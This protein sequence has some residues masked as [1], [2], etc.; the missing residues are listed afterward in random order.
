MTAVK[1]MVIITCA[2]TG[3]GIKGIAEPRFAG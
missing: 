3:L 1:G 2:I